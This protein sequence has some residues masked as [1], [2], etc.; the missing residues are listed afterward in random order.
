MRIL[1]TLIFFLCLSC[2]RAQ[3]ERAP[4]VL[5]AWSI[6]ILMEKGA[7]GNSKLTIIKN[8][9]EY[10]INHEDLERIKAVFA[11]EVAQLNQEAIIYS[12]VFKNGKKT[13]KTTKVPK[14]F[15]QNLRRILRSFETLPSRK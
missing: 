7:D 15:A 4:S 9:G 5:D 6:V 14:E 1:F 13:S 2:L 3:A 10:A 12:A 8:E 11:N